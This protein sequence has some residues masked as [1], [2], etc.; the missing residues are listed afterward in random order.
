[1]K[2]P[3]A[4]AIV[5]AGAVIGLGLFL[6]IRSIRT[7]GT[8]NVNGPAAMAA[9]TRPPPPPPRD[10]AMVRG[11]AVAVLEQF[12][13]HMIESCWRPAL[14]KSPKP[15]TS[16]FVVNF[17]FAGDGLEIA[18]GISE[19][20]D[21]PSRPDVAACLRQQPIGLRIPAPGGA[22]QLELPLAFP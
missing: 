18:R 17:T 7:A 2:N 13:R 3:I 20:R 11:D 6:G 21:Q 12:R 4:I 1:M 9:G 16:F 10:P 14:A 22:V 19:V 5:I 8:P 15:A